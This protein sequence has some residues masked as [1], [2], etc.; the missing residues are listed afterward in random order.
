MWVLGAVYNSYKAPEAKQKRFSYD[1]LIFAGLYWLISHYVS[2]QSLT[3]LRFNIFWL[4][5][6]G[7]ALI[8]E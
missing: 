8:Q 2:L 7:T 1:W 6:I 5:W 4:E 3:I